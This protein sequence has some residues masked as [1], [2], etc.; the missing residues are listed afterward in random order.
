MT[1]TQPT[2]SVRSV[3][4]MCIVSKPVAHPNRKLKVN[5]GESTGGFVDDS[6][7]T[8]QRIRRCSATP[9]RVLYRLTIIPQGIHQGGTQLSPK[10]SHSEDRPPHSDN[11]T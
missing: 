1:A 11:F 4:N 8:I 5:S 7:K 2:N 3:T 9:H 10:L 6:Q